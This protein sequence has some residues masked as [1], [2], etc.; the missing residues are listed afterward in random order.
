[1]T[2]LDHVLEKLG[3]KVVF[4]KRDESYSATFVKGESRIV[5]IGSSISDVE[6]KLVN[7]LCHEAMEGA[8]KDGKEE[9]DRAD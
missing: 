8:L 1:M 9:D 2:A 5:V 7:I 4:K 6:S 3:G